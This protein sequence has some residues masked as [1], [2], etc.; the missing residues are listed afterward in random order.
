MQALL[1]RRPARTAVS[2]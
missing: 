2:A 1:G